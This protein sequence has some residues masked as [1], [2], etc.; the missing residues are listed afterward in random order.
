MGD[1]RKE[2]ARDGRIGFRP[3][4]RELSLIGSMDGAG[5]SMHL[6]ARLHNYMSNS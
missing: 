3:A 4:C 2:R 5:N 1:A 6:A